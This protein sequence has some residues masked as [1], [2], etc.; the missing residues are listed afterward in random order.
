MPAE[1]WRRLAS[2]VVS[3]RVALGMSRR[4]LAEKTGVTERTLGKLE[5]GERASADTVAA[6]SRV[7]GW[8]PDSARVIRLGGEP[9][10]VTAQDDLPPAEVDEALADSFE[11]LREW[12][13]WYD[14][15][16]PEQ[17]AAERRRIRGED[18]LGNPKANGSRRAS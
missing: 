7:L 2:Y 11:F 17:Q 14:K 16:T 5:N 4:D 18:E 9:R 6:V 13:A 1:D 12:I 15:L 10:V 8:S 3:R